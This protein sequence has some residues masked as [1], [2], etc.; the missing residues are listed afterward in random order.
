MLYRLGFLLIAAVAIVGG[1]LIGTL[2]ADPVTID[3][4]WVQ[5]EWPLGLVLVGAL[6]V[7]ILF[8]LSLAWLFTILPLRVQLRNARNLKQTLD[9]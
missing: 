8:G 2:N 5:L 3:L 4:L 1:L 9:V 6:A 7:G